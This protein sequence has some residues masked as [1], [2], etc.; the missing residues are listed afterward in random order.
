MKQLIY[1]WLGIDRLERR[2]H[3]Q[4]DTAIEQNKSIQSWIEDDF[5]NFK[6]DKL[7]VMKSIIN[8]NRMLWEQVENRMTTLERVIAELSQDITSKKKKK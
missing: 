8:E 4:L 7:D 5:I 3:Y 1:K 6:Y 2:V